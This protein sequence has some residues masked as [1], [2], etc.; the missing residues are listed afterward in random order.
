MVEIAREIGTLQKSRSTIERWRK[1]W[2]SI[3]QAVKYPEHTIA[4]KKA[5]IARRLSYRGTVVQ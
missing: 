5:S 3:T 2:R 1:P 4:G